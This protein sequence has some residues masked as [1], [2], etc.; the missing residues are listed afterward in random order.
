MASPL[1]REIYELVDW[2]GRHAGPFDWSPIE[3]G[4]GLRVPESFK[5]VAEFFGPGEFSQ[6]LFVAG[7]GGGGVSDSL[8]S[9]VAVWSEP[10]VGADLLRPYRTR[11]AEEGLV[12]WGSTCQGDTLFWL[13]C[14]PDPELWPILALEEDSAAWHRFDMT[15]SEFILKV[16]GPNGGVDPFSV[17]RV[18]NPSFVP[19]EG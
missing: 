5:E 4:L 1:V 18:V 19:A 8:A 15:V 10:N 11:P 2:T 12:A 3:R 9:Q 13:P 16:I 7:P 14:S 17:G 6:Y